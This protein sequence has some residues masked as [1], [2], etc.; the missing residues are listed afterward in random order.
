L[1]PDVVDGD[2][3]A[4]H[5]G[6][7]ACYVRGRPGIKRLLASGRHGYVG[8]M[9][10]E[11]AAS[12]PAVSDWHLVDLPIELDLRDTWQA[13][14]LVDAAAPDAVLRLAATGNL[15][16]AFRGTETTLAVNVYRRTAPASGAE[17][18]R[19][20]RSHC[21]R[22]RRGRLWTGPGVGSVNRRNKATRAAQPVFGQQG[23]GRSAVLPMDGQ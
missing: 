20:R 19:L 10:A 3:A 8:S 1:A 12:A 15:A 23:R 9:P 17:A 16:N 11:L 22:W 6:G 14:A 7:I 13:T 21:V 2:G 4:R 18:P 5:Q